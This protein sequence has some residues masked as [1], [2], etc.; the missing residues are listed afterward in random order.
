MEVCK[1]IKL[2][3]YGYENNRKIISIA[4]RVAVK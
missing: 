3:W 2:Q 4:Q 1:E